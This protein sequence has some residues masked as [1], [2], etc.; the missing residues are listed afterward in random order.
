[1]IRIIAVAAI[2]LLVAASL[3][4]Q[5]L[6]QFEV[7]TIKPSAP[8][9]D[10]RLTVTMGGD[11]G[12]IDYQ[13]L[14]LRILLSRAFNV[15]DIQISG[16]D[17]LDTE[18]FDVIGKI[19]S[20]VSRDKVPAMLQALFVERFKIAFHHDQKEM[21]I[22]ALVVGK[23]GLKLKEADPSGVGQLF[24]RTGHVETK[25]SLAS[26]ADLLSRMVDRPAFDMTSLKA[27]YDIHLEWTPEPG[28]GSLFK[29]LASPPPAVEGS[30]NPDRGNSDRSGPS[31][32]SAI[33][34]QLGLKLESRKAPVDIVVI[35][36]IEKTPTEN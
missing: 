14:P 20:G 24:V 6:P 13:G 11:P 1:M 25:G 2:A 28:Q 23:N 10:G 26:L 4:G 30:G 22:Y 31:L 34:E 29:G 12:R 15:K 19:P 17:W 9:A 16:P 27:N 35:D 3:E 33:Q 21:G 18:R 32:F 7:A 5:V 36:H 8:V